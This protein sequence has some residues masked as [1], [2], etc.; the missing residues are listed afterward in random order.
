MAAGQHRVGEQVWELVVWEQPAVV[1]RV[2]A[3]AWVPGAHRVAVVH[4]A[5]AAAA[6]PVLPEV[7]PGPAAS[8]AAAV[9]EV[10][11]LAVDPS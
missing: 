7:V 5:V 6:A 9:A 3:A 11:D 4:P 8:A 2:A 1:H 10:S